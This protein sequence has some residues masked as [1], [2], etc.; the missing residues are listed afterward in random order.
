M[1][2]LL[3]SGPAAK[4]SLG[5]FDIFVFAGL[6]FNSTQI[7]SR[8]NGREQGSKNREGSVK[9]REAHNLLI[10]SGLMFLRHDM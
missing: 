8:M 1:K 7:V 6:I 10:A 5:S 4:V 9:V 3:S 2:S